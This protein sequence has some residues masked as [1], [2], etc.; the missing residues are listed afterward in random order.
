MAARGHRWTMELWHSSPAEICTSPMGI[1]PI[2]STPPKRTSGASKSWS[3]CPS[4]RLVPGL[5]PPGKTNI[6]FWKF[7][8][9]FWYIPSTWWIF[10]PAIVYRSGLTQKRNK[11]IFISWLETTGSRHLRSRKQRCGTPAAEHAFHQ[12]YSTTAWMSGR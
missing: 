4:T 9:I 8:K 1:T 12:S 10:Q 7:P 3:F 2:N 5:Y 11:D 6:A